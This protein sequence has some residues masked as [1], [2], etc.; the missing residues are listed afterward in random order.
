MRTTAKAYGKID[1]LILNGDLPNHS[2]DISNFTTIHRIASE[3]T[4]GEI[5][6]VFSRGNHDMR[7]IY[8]ENIAEHTPTDHGNSYYTFRLGGVWGLVLDCAEDKND[9]HPEY[10][11]CNCCHAFRREQTKFIE[12]V[13][14]NAADAEVVAE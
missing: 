1:F 10:G 13:I 6:V 7:G 5:P 4:G 14:K 11:N 12:S 9:D 8:A 3:I 2:G